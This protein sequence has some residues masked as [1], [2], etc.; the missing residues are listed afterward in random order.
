MW[1]ILIPNEYDFLAHTHL[2]IKE[3]QNAR[4]YLAIHD[5]QNCQQV[6]SDT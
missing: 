1:I 5:R 3:R 4:E 2:A 6:F